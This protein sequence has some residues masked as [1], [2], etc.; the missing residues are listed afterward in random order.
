[1][2]MKV[3]EAGE[4]TSVLVG[5]NGLPLAICDSRWPVAGSSRSVC[6]LK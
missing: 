6:A 2:D 5:L 3:G 4:W 1:M